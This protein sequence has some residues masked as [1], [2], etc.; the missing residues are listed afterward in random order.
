MKNTL[1]YASRLPGAGVGPSRWAALMAL[2]LL[3]PVATLGETA[4]LHWWP[5]AV[6]ETLYVLA[7]LWL[8]VLPAVWLLRVE[9][10]RLSWSRPER[11]GFGVAVLLGLLMGGAIVGA[12]L[13]VRRAGLI[14]VSHIRTVVAQHHLDILGVYLSFMIVLSLA[15]S[16]MEEYVWRWFVFRKCETLVGKYGGVI[17]ASLFFTLHHTCSLAAYFNWRVTIM[18][19]VGVFAGGVIWSAM[20]M[21]YRSIW[22]GYVCHIMADAGITVVGYLLIFG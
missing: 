17:G 20:Y 7:K 3:V 4:A 6:G 15:N 14:D 18:G 21:R 22:P 8:L 19:S 13:I 12:Y 1:N 5:G 2:L 11:G 9:Q 10:Q 16:L